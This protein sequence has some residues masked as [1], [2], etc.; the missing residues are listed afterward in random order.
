MTLHLAFSPTLCSPVRRSLFFNWV[1]WCHRRS[2][3]TQPVTSP[4]VKQALRN[5]SP[6]L[7]GSGLTA[8]GDLS[9]CNVLRGE[10]GVGEGSWESGRLRDWLKPQNE[11]WV[12][13]SGAGAGRRMARHCPARCQRLGC[14]PYTDGPVEQQ[15]LLQAQC[16]PHSWSLCFLRTS[17]RNGRKRLVKLIWVIYFMQP[18]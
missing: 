18:T 1:S 5:L 16:G 6:V 3:Q 4:S 9:I 8:W 11:E 10:L 14:T 7:S 15:C 2:R 17:W 13:S 12:G